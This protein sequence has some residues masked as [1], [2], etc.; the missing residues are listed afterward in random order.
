MHSVFRKQA[1]DNARKGLAGCRTD[2]RRTL[3]HGRTLFFLLSC[4]MSP[5]YSSPHCEP[6]KIPLCE[7]MPYNKT[8]MP[9][10]LYHSTQQNAVLIAEQF[11][12][13]V[14]TNCSD[15][16]TFF[17]CAM[18]A[19][20]CTTAIQMEPVP[21]CRNVCHQARDGC[22]PIMNRYNVSWPEELDCRKLPLYDTGVCV[23][24][25]AI[26]RAPPKSKLGVF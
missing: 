23:M 11:T 15:V 19:P 14:D 12:E 10:L 3:R 7:S 5:V 9:N 21:P 8:R 4:L 6:V 2:V 24:P 22:E 1:A 18:F 25:E 16:L 13:L 26:V 17:L 20:I